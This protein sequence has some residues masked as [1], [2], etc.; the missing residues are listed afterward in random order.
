MNALAQL[1]H[2]FLYV[3]DLDRTLAFYRRL[4]PGWTLRWEGT[5]DGNRRWVHLG[6][7]GDGPVGYLSLCEA[8]RG[9]A[10]TAGPSIAVD[11]VGFSHP[12]VVALEAELAVGGIVPYDR[13]DEPAFLRSYFRDPDGHSLE[14]VQHR[15][16]P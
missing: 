8:P 16:T 6:P 2:A 1:E 14:L 9:A 5:A 10:R 15:R 13:V 11:H 12:D 4:L 7:P 3:T